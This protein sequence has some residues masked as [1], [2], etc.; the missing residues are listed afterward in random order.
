[1]TDKEFLRTVLFKRN[2]PDIKNKSQKLLIDLYEIPK[3][4]KGKEIRHY[5]RPYKA[6]EQQ[7]ADILFLPTDSFGY[8]YCLVVVDLHDNRCDAQPLKTKT[9]KEVLNAFENIYKRGILKLPTYMNVDEGTEFKGIVADY[10]R[11]NNVVLT[12]SAVGRHSANAFAEYINKLVGRGIFSIQN[13]K[14]LET[15][16]TNKQWVKDL[17]YVVEVI[18]EKADENHKLNIQHQLT[19][20]K[21][22]KKEEKESI[23]GESNIDKHI[24]EFNK[25][26]E[27]GEK[28]PELK[29]NVPLIDKSNKN[30]GVLDE[31]QKVRYKLDYPIDIA[32]GKRLHGTFRSGD[33]RWS[34]TEHKIDKVLLLPNQ[35]ISYLIS[36]IKNKSFLRNELQLIN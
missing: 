25:K 30:D 22:E 32:T 7:Q 2:K 18:N 29:L 20:A 27:K 34:L 26:I 28:I 1:M 15:N 5:I 10:F 13:V 36:G 17:K 6:N 24:D 11:K 33:I 31:G 8:K 9:N 4:N 21:K 3:K 16:K 23:K 14:E 19:E 12:V 35:P